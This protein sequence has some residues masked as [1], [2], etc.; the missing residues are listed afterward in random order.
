MRSSRSHSTPTGRKRTS[1]FGRPGS[2]ASHA[3][4][5]DLNMRIFKSGF[6]WRVLK[7][8][9]VRF[10][11]GDALTHSAALAY[12]M[13]FSLPPALLIVLWGAGLFY[14][15][16]KMS[17]AIFTEVAAL[18]GPEGTQQLMTT[19]GELSIEKPTLWTTVA[20][21]GVMLFT[22]ST[23]LVAG[24]NALNRLLGYQAEQ[25]PVQA[26]WRMLRD[27]FLSLAMLLTIALILL[28]SMVLNAF[29]AL[30]GGVLDSWN[31]SIASSVT[32][33]DHAM[34]DL[35]V[36]SALFAMLFRYLPDVRLKWRE[37][38][39]A[40]FLTAIM[41]MAGQYL[42]GYII[43]QSD[44]A[45]YYDAAGSVLVLMLW[46]YYASAIFLFG[47]VY[48]KARSDLLNAYPPKF[49]PAGGM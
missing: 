20:A 10:L 8:S 35:V 7:E 9:I 27:R 39:F 25:A 36:M 5:N 19:L 49:P 1:R 41:F 46:V 16:A 13:V 42:I 4:S 40:A 17:E 11:D 47:A 14:Q 26:L 3:N 23:V 43:G 6:H 15:E 30:L 21:T 44:A 45:N 22:A 33:L 2:R 38:W 37:T 18:V 12:F 48:T 32:F 31:P 29:V 28:V 34:L 24:Q